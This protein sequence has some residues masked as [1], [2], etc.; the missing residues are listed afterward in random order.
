MNELLCI[1][2]GCEYELITGDN[3]LFHNILKNK[4]IAHKTFIYRCPLH[5]MFHVCN[6]NYGKD[7]VIVDGKCYFSKNIITPSNLVHFEGG[8]QVIKTKPIIKT[9]IVK[10]LLNQFNKYYLG[11]QVQSYLKENNIT[12]GTKRFNS[13]IQNLH[14]YISSYVY[15]KCNKQ[16]TNLERCSEKLDF[17]IQSIY[18]SFWDK[19]IPTKFTRNKIFKE[20][21]ILISKD[22]N[23]LEKDLSQKFD[24]TYQPEDLYLIRR[25][26]RNKLWKF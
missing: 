11:T 1:S 3:I 26:H 13:I 9:P 17:I 8:R 21:N 6:N 20:I 19:K 15:S 24:S 18:Y 14:K 7:C 23:C 10:K 16:H 22:L 12:I 5:K 4:N 2:E 25:R